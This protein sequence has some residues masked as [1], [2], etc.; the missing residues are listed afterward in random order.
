MSPRH[1]PDLSALPRL[2]EPLE[3]E[4]LTAHFSVPAE[5]LEQLRDDDDVTRVGPAPSDFLDSERT[6][7]IRSGGVHTAPTLP[8]PAPVSAPVAAPAPT[9]SAVQVSHQVAPVAPVRFEPTSDADLAA[10][11]S[12]MRRPQRIA[13]ATF[14]ALLVVV[15]AIVLAWRVLTP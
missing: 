11:I 1:R 6:I 10:Q 4:E 13:L 14:V 8:P 2:T 15:G 5:L 9:A 7:E 3:N 12:A